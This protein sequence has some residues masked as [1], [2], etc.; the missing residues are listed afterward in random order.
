ML[1]SVAT[2]RAS[3]RWSELSQASSGPTTGKCACTE[4]RSRF[5]NPRSALRQG[6]SVI[7]Q[8]LTQVPELSVAENILLGRL[9]RSRTGIIDWKSV[10]RIAAQAL[11][12][13]G[14]DLDTSVRL[15][16]LPTGLRQQVEIAR[17]ITSQPKYSDP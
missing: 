13:L 15:S 1:Y 14:L 10:R 12:E 7:Y 17:A 16:S 9:P 6:V 5:D 8:E 11:A 4:C 3:R 2:A